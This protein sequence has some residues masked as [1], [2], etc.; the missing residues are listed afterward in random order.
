MSKKKPD[1]KCFV[2]HGTGNRCWDDAWGSEAGYIEAGVPEKN[3][4]YCVVGYD[5]IGNKW[6]RSNDGEQE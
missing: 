1:P 5:Q 2:C 6:P 4:C 3:N